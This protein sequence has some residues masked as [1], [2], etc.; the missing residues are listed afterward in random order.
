M[1]TILD[2]S[3]IWQCEIPG[4]SGPLRLPG[5]LDES[6][7]G[8]QDDPQ[9]QWKVDEVARIGFYREG[10]PIVTRL[11]RKAAF[12]G[13]AKI[14]RVIN[15]KVPQGKRLFIDVE[16]ARHL[17]LLVNGEEIPPYDP[18]SVSTPYVFEVTGKL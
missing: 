6:G 12:E 3:G 7:I 13:Q 4:Q 1:P 15:L 17:R 11:T 2:L 8:F 14:S 9:K 16:R 5:T 10:D 18:P